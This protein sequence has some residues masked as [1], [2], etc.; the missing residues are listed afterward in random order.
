MFSMMPRLASCR[1]RWAT[2]RAVSQSG[3]RTSRFPLRDLEHALDL[4]R[5]I[6]GKGSDADGGAGMAALVAEGGNHQ[7]GSA[8]QHLRPIEKVRRGIDETAEPD[9]AD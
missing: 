1:P 6:G 7:V 4:D 5:G 9:H 2:G 8:V 3:T